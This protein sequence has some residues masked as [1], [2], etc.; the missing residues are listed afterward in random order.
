[1]DKLGAPDKEGGRS[2]EQLEAVLTA[3][4]FSSHSINLQAVW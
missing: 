4:G 3:Q 2:Q 1:M